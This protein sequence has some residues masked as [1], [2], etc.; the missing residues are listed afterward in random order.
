MLRPGVLLLALSLLPL[1]IANADQA[2][3]DP[4]RALAIMLPSNAMYVAWLP[5]MSAAADGYRVYGFAG[6]SATLLNETDLLFAQ[7]QGGYDR[8]VVRAV[9]GSIESPGEQADQCIRFSIVPPDVTP[10]ANP[11]DCL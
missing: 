3:Q 11:L 8:Y 2:T 7:V 1:Q 6:A 10:P 4:E 5:P 9:Y